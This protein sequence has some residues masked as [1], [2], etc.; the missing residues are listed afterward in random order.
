MA[1]KIRCAECEFCICFSSMYCTRGK[2]NCKHPDY[3]H[4]AEYFKTH[5]LKKMPGFIGFG[6][7]DRYIPDIKTSPAWCPKK[8][9][10]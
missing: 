4:I 6:R 5:G 7:S 10:R 3:E 2:Y 8:K 1:D 9:G